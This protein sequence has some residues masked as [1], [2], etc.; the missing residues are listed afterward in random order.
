MKQL[1]LI[2]IVLLLLSGC[3]AP[4][5]TSEA[6]HEK[7]GDMPD[8]GD[9]TAM[10]ADYTGIDESELGKILSMIGNADITDAR[11]YID[12]KGYI[13]AFSQSQR[14]ALC[15]AVQN[16]MNTEYENYL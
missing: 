10:A 6:V 12:D 5:A 2:I 4:A 3:A 7:T 11:I 15:V 14:E 13:D 1:L 9:G 8:A 16:V